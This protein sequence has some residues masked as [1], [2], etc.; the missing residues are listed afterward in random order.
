[1]L[2]AAVSGLGTEVDA[3]PSEQ[4]E[5]AAV[6]YP[7]ALGTEAAGVLGVALSGGVSAVQSAQI[8]VHFAS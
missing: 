7:R 4:V 2:C 1:M 8:V 3:G 6:G 5:E